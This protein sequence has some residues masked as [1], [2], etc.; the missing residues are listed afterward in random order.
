M[1]SIKSGSLKMVV[2]TGVIVAG[3]CTNVFA[4]FSYSNT[5]LIQIIQDVEA[6]TDYSFLYRN[7]LISDVNLSLSATREEL[8]PELNKQLK[9]HQLDLQI[10]EGRKQIIIIK[11]NSVNKRT[12]YVRIKGQ[13]VDA[14][15]GERLP[16][17]VITWKEKQQLQGLSTN[18]SG[19]F[20]ID[21]S[22]AESN[23]EITCS[24]FGYVEDKVTLN[25]EEGANIDELTFRL[26]P[27]IIDANQ[28]LITG[29]HYYDN[30]NQYTSDVINIGTF[31]PMGEGNTTSALQM[32]PSVSLAPSLSGDVNIRGS[33][34]DALKVL[35][36]DIT[37]YNKS[38][39]F[40]LIDSFNS[41]VL[42]RS[43][44]YY[45]ITPLKY[46]APPGG[47]LTLI[48][49]T[50]SLDAFSGS[51][52]LSNSSF[53]ISLEGPL[54]TGKSSWLFSARKSYMNTLNWFNNFELVQWGLNVDRKRGGIDNSLI[55]VQPYLE[56]P[57][58]TKASFFDLHGKFYMEGKTGAG[59]L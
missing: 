30:I 55:N 28:L 50:G 12:N 37:I 20:L 2:L 19:N 7:A 47:T 32:L 52:G 41:D 35:I 9:A 48:T 33:S 4:Q 17:A 44:F 53:R 5:P 45:D 16:Y 6:Q 13:A 57:G 36:D 11:M 59:L 23:I 3:A 8:F 31:S 14:K 42:R 51:A 22:I 43:G 39:L 49:K 25:L 29:T 15:T 10:N 38:H 56:R 24:Y 21:R 54:Q 40:G 58:E 1:A 26:Q 27:D 18:E 34:A 46:Q